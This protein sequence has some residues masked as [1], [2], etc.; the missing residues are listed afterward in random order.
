[1]RLAS[2]GANGPRYTNSAASVELLRGA[3]KFRSI[4]SPYNNRKNLIWVRAVKVEKGWPAPTSGSKVG[5]GHLTA[6][7]Y[8]FPYVSSGIGG[9]NPLLGVCAYRLKGDEEGEG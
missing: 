7:G 5:A 8:P 1:L 4:L 3:A 2:V 9:F 6:H